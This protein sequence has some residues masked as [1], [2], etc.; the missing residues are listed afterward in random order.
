MIGNAN[1]LQ[2]TECQCSHW[3]ALPC[4]TPANF[5]SHFLAH[6]KQAANIWP[7]CKATCQS[8]FWK[9]LNNCN[10]TILELATNGQSATH[11]FFEVAELLQLL[12]SLPRPFPLSSRLDPIVRRSSFLDRLV[13]AFDGTQMCQCHSRDPW[14]MVF[15]DTFKDE[16]T[17]VL[18]PGPSV[19]A[20]DCD[21]KM[22][23]RFL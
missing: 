16:L 13:V 18:S 15:L 11:V 21:D 23:H 17:G 12:L 3:P 4:S 22:I 10:C 1:R 8:N 20:A 6:Y 9:P 14:S 5:I 19:M 2:P 7:C